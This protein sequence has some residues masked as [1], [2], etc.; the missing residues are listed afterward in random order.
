MNE[1]KHIFKLDPAKEISDEH[2][3]M[4]CESGTDAV[5]VGGTDDITLDG[6]L[7]LLAR[8]RR[9]TVPCILEI[10]SMDAITPGFD[11]YYIPMVLN[12]KEK[13]WMMDIQHQAIKEF[14]D[15]M[16]YSEILFE[17]YCILNE[18]AKAFTHTNSY[19]PDEEDV[20]AY[21]Y[22]AEKVF[23]LPVFYMEYSGKYGD[24]ELVKK[25]KQQLDETKL[26]YGGG[27]ETVQQARDMKENADVIIVGNIIYTDIKKAIKT[28][29]A[30]KDN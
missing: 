17:G 4:I 29:K 1:W 27:I 7:D 23:H 19:L 3:E 21:A 11:Y 30:I 2:L 24:P 10:S 9:Y 5:I 13:K 26:F 14:V 12:S 15:M 28:V 20:I 8:V 18:E 22:M 16:E 25:V 6:V